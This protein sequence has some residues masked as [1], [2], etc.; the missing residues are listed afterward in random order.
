MTLTGNI[1]LS[2]P[3]R[4]TFTR[5]VLHP[6]NPVLAAAVR[7]EAA[8]ARVLAFLDTHVAQAIPDLPDRL[9]RYAAAHA[10]TMQVTG[11]VQPVIGGEASKNDRDAMYRVLQAIEAARVDRQSY[12]LAI[13]GGAVLD[14]VGFAAAIA[15]RGVRLIRM[16]TTTLAQADSGVGVKNG[17]NG[18]GKKNFLGTFAVPWAVLIDE[19][20]LLTLPDLEWRC[21]FVEAV[22]VALVKDAAFF[23]RIEA[24]ASSIA[25]RDIEHAMP[26]IQR[27]AELHLSHIAT[28]GDP[29]ELTSAR[30]LDFGHWAAHKLEAMTGFE[31]RHGEAVAIGIALDATYAHRLGML[32]AHSLARILSCLRSL[33]LPLWH[34]ALRHEKQ[35]LAGLDEFREHLGGRLTVTMLRAIGRGEDVHEIDRDV[36]LAAAADLVPLAA[37]ASVG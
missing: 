32:D 22:K 34:E 27:S 35:L 36:M 13:G 12:V 6:D 21:G 1:Q 17:I 24:A 19:R 33:G 4:V 20:F 2:F 28:G 10:D 18:F 14:C 3:H 7:S 23:D 30:P 25:R 9:R 16:P 26:V 31:L 11:R 8:P 29:F 5:D 37:R 15:H